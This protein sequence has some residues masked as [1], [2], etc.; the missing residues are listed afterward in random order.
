MRK[1]FILF[2]F[3]F[4]FLFLFS[5]IS[6]AEDIGVRILSQ[7]GSSVVRIM[8]DQGNDS[9]TISTGFFIN[10]RYIVTNH[11]CV[12]TYLK[13][14]LIG[15]EGWFKSAKG[16]EVL[17]IYSE[18][19]EDWTLGIVVEDWPEVDLAVIDIKYP[20]TKRDP[21]KIASEN[22]IKNGMDVFVVGFP[23]IFSNAYDLSTVD[24]PKITKG[25]LVST[26]IHNSVEDGLIGYKQQCYSAL[27]NP[28]NS[29][30]PVVD[31]NGN[32]IGIA[33]ASI[34]SN[35]E[36]GYFG[37]DFRELISRLDVVGISYKTENSSRASFVE[38]LDTY[39]AEISK[40][41]EYHSKGITIRVGDILTLGHYEQDNNLDNGPEDIEWLVLSI[42]SGQAL[43]ISKYAIE[44]Q[45]YHVR[46]ESVTWESSTLR[47]WLNNMFYDN[48]FTDTEK[49]QILTVSNNNY[50][51][52]VYNTKGGNATRDKVFL[53]SMDEANKYLRNYLNRERICRRSSYVEAKGLFDWLD[54][55]T[56]WWWLRSPGDTSKSAL[57]VFRNGSAN[58]IGSFVN[59]KNGCVRPALW[60][61]LSLWLDL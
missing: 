9:V 36:I 6:K 28:G 41:P 54:D 19:N 17:V 49:G 26:I 34:N 39:F 29:G 57:C 35:G 46:R 60:L 2:L 10:N 5:G 47:F 40:I 44:V 16:T 58:Y 25:N 18:K 13:S 61:D 7:V 51:N 24:E 42:E 21:V 27:I 56:S 32:V 1:Q 30:G 11:H 55:D 59:D 50:D 22:D 15:A 52:P 45:P 53:L 8:V 31:N 4:P 48:S 43:L 37:I 14:N 12:S 38:I 3:I 33:N 23:G 20:T